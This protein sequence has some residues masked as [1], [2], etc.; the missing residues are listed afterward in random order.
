MVLSLRIAD[1]NQ[2]TI[3]L[4]DTKDT[5]ITEIN[6]Y[7]DDDKQALINS[8]KRYR[9]DAEEA[10]NQDIQGRNMFDTNKFTSPEGVYLAARTYRGKRPDVFL[11]SD[12]AKRKAVA[13]AR[14]AARKAAQNAAAGGASVPGT[15]PPSGVPDSN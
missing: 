14:E 12:V 15:P 7:I 2:L 1:P 4:R 13:A 11:Y 9:E 3:Y 10:Y 5:A 8:I 6:K